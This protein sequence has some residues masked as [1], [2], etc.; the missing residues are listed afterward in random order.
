LWKLENFGRFVEARKAL[1][2]DK[3]SRMLR[4]GGDIS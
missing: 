1:I 4:S 3:F 2:A